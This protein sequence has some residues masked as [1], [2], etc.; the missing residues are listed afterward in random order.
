MRMS[1]NEAIRRINEHNYIHQEKE[2]RAVYI[3]EAFDVVIDTMRKYQKIEQII[4]KHDADRIP[5]DYW[6][7]DKIR[8]VVEDE[9]N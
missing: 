4:K 6:Y 8:E 5:E 2:P 3:S 7:I 1:I 9:H